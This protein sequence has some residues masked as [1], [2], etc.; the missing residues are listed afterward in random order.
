MQIDGQ[1]PNRSGFLALQGASFCLM[2]WQLVVSRAAAGTALGQWQR[3]EG[4]DHA[5][6]HAEPGCDALVQ[7]PA[8]E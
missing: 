4:L 3:D 6:G 1:K 8:G 5:G 2:R 7:P